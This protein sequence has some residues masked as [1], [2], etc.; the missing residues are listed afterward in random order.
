MLWTVIIA[1]GKGER[2][3]GVAKGLLRVGETTVIERTLAQVPPGSQFINANQTEPYEFLGI[4]IVG[5]VLP[6]RG[7]PGGVVTALA[8]CPSQWV[9]ALACDMPRLTAESLTR[10]SQEAAG[11]GEAEVVCFERAG[12]IEPLVAFYRRSLLHRWAGALESNPSLRG[13]IRSA[14]L[15]AL[16]CPDPREL[17]SVNTADDARR[18]GVQLG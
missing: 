17:D 1:G 8:V 4:P 7:A 9:L 14:R 2:L 6:N 11:N 18:L 10:L 13:L 12:D 15:K 5:D 16:K 3:G